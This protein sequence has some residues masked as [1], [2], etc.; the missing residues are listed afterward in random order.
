MKTLAAIFFLFFSFIAIPSV[1]ADSIQIWSSGGYLGYS[2]NSG[3]GQ[4]RHRHHHHH[5]HRHWGGNGWN[6]NGWNGNGYS[7]DCRWT[8]SCGGN[9]NYVPQQPR[10]YVQPQPRVIVPEYYYDGNGAQYYYDQWGYVQYTGRYLQRQQPCIDPD[11]DRDC[12]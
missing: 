3:Y 9:Y 7:Q 8:N 11:F 10:I 5:H 6:G 1:Q 2:D 4:Q 12:H